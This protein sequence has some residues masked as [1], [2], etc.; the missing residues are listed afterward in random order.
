MFDEMTYSPEATTFKVFAP[1]SA[2]CFVVVDGDSVKME[3]QPTV[4]DDQFTE[5]RVYKAVVKGDLKG[6]TYAF[7]VNGNT[8]PGVFAKA[9]TINGQQGVVVDLRDTDPE[10]WADDRGPRPERYA[11]WVVY[12]MHHRDFSIARSDAQHPGRAVGHCAFEG[13]GRHCRAYP[14]FI[15]LRLGGRDKTRCAAV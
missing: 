4:E 9:V 6:K 8:S 12:E 3:L 11:D 14:A 7:S 1:D 15:R 2:T 5:G 13:F 10:G